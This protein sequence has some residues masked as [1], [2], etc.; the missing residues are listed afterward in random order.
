MTDPSVITAVAGNGLA[1][2]TLNR[3]GVHN[4]FDDELISRLSGELERLEND[5][6]VGVVVLAAEGKSFCA[7]ADLNWMK[8]MADFTEAENLA[9]AETVA[10]LMN[11]LHGLS[12]PT[13]ARV[14]GAAFGG[15]VG[16]VACCD[17]AIASDAALFS[18]SEVK[19]GLVPAMISPYVVAAIG[20]RQARR[21]MLS[22]ER[23]DAADAMR[24][25]LVHAV[26]AAA[27]LD[28]AVAD[29]AGALLANGPAAM[30][31]VK[32]LIASI[33]GRPI[34]SGLIRET[35]ATIARLRVSDEGREGVAAFLEKRKPDWGK[36]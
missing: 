16:L 20:E 24:I 17:I 32:D 36:R 7:G 15:G 23:F 28:Q 1:T 33:A 25:G 34:D 9:D 8:R 14:Q 35:A 4:A 11:C 18:L 12:K 6:S 3:P 13:I 26:V 22:A 30:A 29:M 5:P 10:R 21:Y 27:D 2:V 19:L 31:E